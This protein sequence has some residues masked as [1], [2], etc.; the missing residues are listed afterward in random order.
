V[1]HPVLNFEKEAKLDPLRDMLAKVRTA[2]LSLRTPV[3]LEDC[4]MPE[5]VSS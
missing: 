4:W 2:L 1:K 5:E 3:S